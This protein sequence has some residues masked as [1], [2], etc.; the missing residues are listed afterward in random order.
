MELKVQMALEKETKGA[1]RYKELNEFNPK[2]GTLYIRK[3]NFKSM[4]EVPGMI[5]ITIKGING[6]T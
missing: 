3:T 2:I 1:I 5:E 6:E 4:D